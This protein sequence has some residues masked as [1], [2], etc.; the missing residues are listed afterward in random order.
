MINYADEMRVLKR[1]GNYEEISFD[2]IL[3]R[4]KACGKKD[5][6]KINYSQLCLKVIDQLFDGIKTTQ[7]DELT[8]E[9]CASLSTSH[10]EYGKLSSN[11]IV[12]NHHKNTNSSFFET[13]KLLHEFEDIHKNKSKLISSDL[14]SVINDN[15]E[16][17]ENEIDYE[18][19]YLF[20][21]FG[22]KTL[23]RAY[24]MRINGTIVERPQHMWMR[25]AIGIHG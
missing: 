19:D 4:V 23:E 3:K 18:K 1:D 22:F 14:Y 25:V 9:Q 8:A 5:D 11:I 24:L 2:K 7:I 20:D 16:R 6:L 12:S 17:I 10:P 13:M 15:K 21:Y